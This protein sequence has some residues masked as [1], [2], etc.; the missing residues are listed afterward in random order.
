LDNPLLQPHSV[1]D[2]AVHPVLKKEK[3]CQNYI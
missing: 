2:V 3:N 1:A